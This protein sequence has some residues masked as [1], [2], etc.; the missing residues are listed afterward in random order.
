MSGLGIARASDFVRKAF[1]GFQIGQ[2]TEMKGRFEMKKLMIAASAALCATVGFSDVTSANIVGYMQNP[3]VDGYK[4]VAIPFN[5]VG[6]TVEGKKGVRLSSIVPEGADTILG[7]VSL[8]KLNAQGLKDGSVYEY[9]KNDPATDRKGKPQF[10]ND[11]WYNDITYITPGG[12][13]DIFLPMGSGVWVKG[14]STLNFT[15]SGEVNL[16][17][18]NDGLVDG[19]RLVANPYPT[20]IKLSAFVPQGVDTILGTVSLQKL[21]AEGLKDGSVYEYHKND[22]AT[23]RKGKPQFANDGWYNDITYITPGGATDIEI[24]A[25]SAVWVKGAST[26]TMDVVTPFED[27]E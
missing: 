17:T 4:A 22:P 21:N 15:P 20:P 24:P 8:Q 3:L 5:A 27:F 14:A 12:A 7:T 6:V 1:S 13:T 10:P 25:G 9:H 11:G 26:I 23:D 19:Y 16:D 2:G 18:I